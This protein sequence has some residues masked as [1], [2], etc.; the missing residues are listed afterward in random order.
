MRW[1]GRLFLSIALAAM[2]VA[3]LAAQQSPSTGKDGGAK[4]ATSG[5]ATDSTTGSATDDSPSKAPPITIQRMRANDQRGLNIFEAPKFDDVPFDGFRLAFGA[6]F[7]Q[8]FQS[9]SHSNA[10]APKMVDGVDQNALKDIGAGFDNAAANLYLNAQLA[11][12]IR[13]ALT[14]YLSSRHHSEAWVKDG[15][16]L[17]DQSPIDWLPLQFLMA[18]TTVKAGHFEIDYGDAH[19]RRSDNGQALYDPFVGN[20]ILDGF[21]TEIGGEVL[22]RPGP[23]IGMVGVTGGEVHGEVT[24]PGRRSPAIY[25][26]LGFD[27]QVTPDVRVR[28][29]GSL[30]SQAKSLSNTLYH[31]DRGGS[32][33]WYVLENTQASS[34]SQAWSGTINPQFGSEI[35][36][37]MINPFVKVGRLEVFGVAE[38]AKGRSSSET[39]V[40]KWT[41]YDGD[42]V[43]RFL[44]GD[45]LYV[46]GRYNLAKGTLPGIDGDVRVARAELAGGWFITPNLLLKGEYVKQRYNDFPTTDIRSGGR[47]DGLM[48][49]GVVSF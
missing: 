49:Q 39:S 43:Y 11:P 46:G 37:F 33:F 30:F 3:P 20:L 8:Q 45:K 25:G 47:F 1:H 23:L 38:Q 16:L 18:F 34:S 28:L 9:L 24:N 31:G 48:L 22:V 21:T 7:A 5:S 40:R 19:F 44:E 12:G 36:S 27:K 26:K 4:T 17:I 35:H 14:T 41:Q 10:A 15:Y 13:V 32:P 6:A 2:G 29:T 42:V